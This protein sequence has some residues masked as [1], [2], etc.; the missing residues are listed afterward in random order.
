LKH[1]IGIISRPPPAFA[2]PD[3]IAVRPP[4]EDRGVD[5]KNGSLA[6]PVNFTRT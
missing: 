2:P 3:T 1:R 4:G 5:N 6:T